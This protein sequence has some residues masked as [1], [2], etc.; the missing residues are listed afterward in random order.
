MTFLSLGE[1]DEISIKRIFNCYDCDNLLQNDPPVVCEAEHTWVNGS[2]FLDIPW[3]IITNVTFG[4][5]LTSSMQLPYFATLGT[6]LLNRTGSRLID[7]AVC[8]QD[9]NCSHCGSMVFGE[10]GMPGTTGQLPTESINCEQETQGN[11]V[12]VT[13]VNNL[14]EILQP[15]TLHL[16]GKCKYQV[17]LLSFKQEVCIID[18]NSTPLSNHAITQTQITF[19]STSI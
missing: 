14:A 9:E 19:K 2:I 12:K 11:L 4:Y 13:Q 1:I 18:A 16:Y 17:K 8:V 15:C 7:V 10:D 5:G 3:A 6:F